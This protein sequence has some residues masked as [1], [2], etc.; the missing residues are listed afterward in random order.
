MN[1][2]G[3]SCG[4]TGRVSEP[5][6]RRSGFHHAEE[7]VR[8]ASL[9]DRRREASAQRGE[10]ACL[11]ACLQRIKRFLLERLGIHHDIGNLG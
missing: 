4:R 8:A 1:R 9:L 5:N 6:G 3:G 7:A 11:L 10:L 2:R